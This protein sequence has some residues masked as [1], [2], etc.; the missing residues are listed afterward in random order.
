MKQENYRESYENEDDDD[1]MGDGY[2]DAIIYCI[3]NN[4]IN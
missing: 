2:A 1:D 3:K 4:L